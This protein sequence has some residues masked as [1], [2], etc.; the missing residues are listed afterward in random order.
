MIDVTIFSPFIKL[1]FR[2]VDIQIAYIYNDFYQQNH[3]DAVITNSSVLNQ[4]NLFIH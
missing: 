3:Q 2:N 4:S 1:I